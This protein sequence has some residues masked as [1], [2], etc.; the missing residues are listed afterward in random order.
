MNPAEHEITDFYAHAVAIERE[1]AARY[2]ELAGQ[3]ATHNNPALAAL[4]EEMSRLEAGH[5][6][7]LEGRCANLRVPIYQPWEYRW[8]GPESP[9]SVPY[10]E[11]HYLMTGRHALEGALAA[12]RRACD[13]FRDIASNAADQELRRLAAD[14]A[15]EEE[16]HIR[17]F[18]R[19]LASQAP[20]A[21]DWDQDTDPPQPLD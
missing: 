10:D 15:E 9:E 18:E 14:L 19:A 1:A 7:E 2:K 11:M 12:E 8:H 3:M 4:F 16:G 20:L 5:L 13:Y 21:P 6:K 17:H